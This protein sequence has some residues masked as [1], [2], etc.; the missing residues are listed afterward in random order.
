MKCMLKNTNFTFVPL[1][2]E[3]MMVNPRKII[4]WIITHSETAKKGRSPTLWICSCSATGVNMW[5]TLHGVSQPRTAAS[6]VPK[7]HRCTDSQTA[8]RNPWLML[9]RGW[10]S[11][12]AIVCSMFPLG[13]TD[14]IHLI[15]H[16]GHIHQQFIETKMWG[17]KCAAFVH[18]SSHCCYK[19]FVCPD[20]IDF[21]TTHK[22]IL[23]IGAHPVV[24]ICRL[25]RDDS[26]PA[27]KTLITRFHTVSF[28]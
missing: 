20:I 24:F 17:I 5:Q 18:T 14:Q 25:L 16:L 11:K 1:L 19:A 3:T 13:L 9:C 27:K 4:V 21:F 7:L 26:R 15:P 22:N 12:Q 23:F 8:A 2:K 28:L 6:G 10:G